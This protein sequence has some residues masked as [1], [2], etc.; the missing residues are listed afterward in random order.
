[1]L[2]HRLALFL[3]HLIGNRLAASYGRRCLRL[4]A[5]MET[6]TAENQRAV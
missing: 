5:I 1:M 6:A 2:N 4:V 3:R